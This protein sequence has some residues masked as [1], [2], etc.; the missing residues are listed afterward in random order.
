M[1]V[2]RKQSAFMTRREIEEVLARVCMWE[3]GLMTRHEE[4]LA[5]N[6]AKRAA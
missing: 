1:I 2:R 6:A 5:L 3:F 4:A